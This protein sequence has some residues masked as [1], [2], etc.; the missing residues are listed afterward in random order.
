MRLVGRFA[1]LTLAVFATATLFGCATTD[2][3]RFLRRDMEQKIGAVDEKVAAVEPKILAVKDESELLRKDVQ[4]NRD[5]LALAR[6]NQANAGADIG[7]LRD[8][9]QQVRG[10][11]DGLRKE[12]SNSA[13]QTK[14]RDEELKELRDK[15][16]GLSFRISFLE[17]FL[18]IGKKEEPTEPQEKGVA[19]AGA[20]DKPKTDKE[21]LYAAA[22][23]VFKEAKYDKARI[24]FQAFLK[25]Y[26]D[27]EL[28]DNAQFW[29]GECYYFENKFEKAILEYEKVVKSYPEGDKVPYAL[30]KQGLS[31]LKLGDKSSARLILQQVIKDFPNTNQAR[32]ARSKLVEIK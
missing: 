21:S 13:A 18:G 3:L 22:Y 25:Q 11:I 1:A 30:L 24:D 31:F 2:D 10:G 28:S 8:A 5:A 19:P 15:L 32:I 12:I 9:V 20:K 23:E 14:K 7:D 26:P 29:I 6:K 4:A 27:T 17:N 16:E